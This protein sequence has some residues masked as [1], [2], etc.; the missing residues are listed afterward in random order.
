[1]T[2]AQYQSKLIKKLTTMFP[3]CVILKNDPAHQQGVPDLVVLW[4]KHWASLEVKLFPM[5]NRQPNQDYYIDTLNEMSFAAYIYPENE[6]EVLDALQQA[7]ES[8]RRA[9][10][11]QS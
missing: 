1:V 5:S 7:F 10:V 11:S 6:E 3:G 8:P 4:H 9:C 2:E